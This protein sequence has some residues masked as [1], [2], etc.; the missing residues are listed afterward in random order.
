[1]IKSKSLSKRLSLI[2]ILAVCLV[3]II[4]TSI[5]Y[6]FNK[7]IAL[8][9][10]D[11]HN[12]VLVSALS[13]ALTLPVWTIDLD[14]I[15]LICQS[16]E[17]DETLI[18]LEIKDDLNNTL[19]SYQA[20]VDE[21]LEF[22]NFNIVYEKAIIGNI[23][24]SFSKVIVNEYLLDIL[25]TNLLLLI[26]TLLTIAILTL[27]VLK[28]L[29]KKPLALLALSASEIESGNYSKVHTTDII[30]FQSLF[31]T[32]NKM[33]SKISKQFSLLE[34][35]KD[36]LEEKVKDEIDKRKTHEQILIQKSRLAD[37]GDMISM[38]AHQWRQPLSAM[39]TI[40]QNIQLAYKL[41]KLDENF[42]DEQCERS[43][44]IAKNM[45][46][47]IDD[48]GNFFKDNKVKDEFYVSEVIKNSMN[49]LKD[50]LHNHGIN[51]NEDF[52]KEEIKLFGYKNELSQ[53]IVNLIMN[54]KD[55]FLNNKNKIKFNINI[56][57][58][59]DLNNT[60]IFLSD[61]A[62][63]I[64]EDIIK[65]I[66]EPYF[67]TKEKKNATGLGLYMSK[68]IIEKNMLGVLSVKNI[69]KGVLFTI[70]LPNE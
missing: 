59:Q 22:S 47:T 60:T 23:K 45:S 9:H 56:K 34:E 12:K 10:F 15:K 43:K 66:F 51:I 42:L 48:F 68:M 70:V 63:G 32:L 4:T 52:G 25:S 40:T 29:L 33:R 28:V 7:K 6:S 58:T 35:N 31:V 46:S 39:T 3:S 55:A 17:V 67:S 37:M 19:Y 26:L 18:F 8:N 16:F 49:L 50:T 62:G 13:S 27:V 69:E 64:E 20:K 24:V 65:K 21:D 5:L 41:D 36:S 57:I 14:S 30:E 2:L 38:I 61:N 54:S 11:E 53:V 1:M 44:K